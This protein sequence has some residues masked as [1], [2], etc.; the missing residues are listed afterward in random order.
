MVFCVTVLGCVKSTRQPTPWDPPVNRLSQTVNVSIEGCVRR[1]WWRLLTGA[2][3]DAEALFQTCDGDDW[4]RLGLG[5]IARNRLDQTA[6]RRLLTPFIDAPTALGELARKWTSEVGDQ[7]WAKPLPI[8]AR[9][10]SH[11]A[12]LSRLAKAR[13]SGLSVST[14][15][16]INPQFLGDHRFESEPGLLWLQWDLPKTTRC[17]QVPRREHSRVFL[18]S[19]EVFADDGYL[20]VSPTTDALRLTMIIA[21][22]TAAEIR[23]TSSECGKFRYMVPAFIEPGEDEWL[24]RFVQRLFSHRPFVDDALSAKDP[25]GSKFAKSPWYT[26]VLVSLSLKS[27]AWDGFRRALLRHLPA[28]PTP[29]LR[30]AASENYLRINDVAQARALIEPLIARGSNNPEVLSVA[31]RIYSASNLD[32]QGRSL[33]KRYLRLSNRRCQDRAR[34]FGLLGERTQY[35]DAAIQWARDCQQDHHALSLALR[36]YRD[37]QADEIFRSRPEEDWRPRLVYQFYVALGRYAEAQRI[38]E[39]AG[40]SWEARELSDLRSR[41]KLDPEDLEKLRLDAA[42]TPQSLRVAAWFVDQDNPLEEERTTSATVPLNVDRLERSESIGPRSGGHYR[43]LERLD[44][45][46]YRAAQQYSE[47]QLPETAEVPQV[48]VRKK[49]GSLY[50]PLSDA[51]KGSLTLPSLSVSDQIEIRYVEPVS[52]LGG[53]RLVKTQ[54]RPMSLPYGAISDSLYTLNAPANSSWK[55]LTSI[56]VPIE[57]TSHN[58][59]VF[60]RIHQKNVPPVTLHP[61]GP[62]YVFATPVVRAGIGNLEQLYFQREAER[63]QKL[64]RLDAPMVWRECLTLNPAPQDVSLM[65]ALSTLAEESQISHWDPLKFVALLSRCLSV[66]NHQHQVILM[67]P[68]ASAHRR[69]DLRLSAFTYPVLKIDG[70]GLWD[71][72]NS[73]MPM[74]MV[75]FGLFDTDGRVIYPLRKAG[76]VFDGPRS[77]KLP[78]KNLVDIQLQRMG[79]EIIGQLTL[80]F[81][82]QDAW[83]VYGRWRHLNP[84]RRAQLVR[85]LVTEIMPL[86]TVRS[87]EFSRATDGRITFRIETENSGARRLPLRMPLRDQLPTIE[88]SNLPDGPIYVDRPLSFELRVDLSEGLEFVGRPKNTRSRDEWKHNQFGYTLTDEVMN[89]N[90]SVPRQSLDTHELTRWAKFQRTLFD[91]SLPSVGLSDPEP[92]EQERD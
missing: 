37:D 55:V 83:R 75:P 57:K 38:A 89:V 69:A 50:F 87:A 68:R 60:Y 14:V 81:F 85:R 49:N 48:Y 18:A 77:S 10:E 39:D 62:A 70:V 78:R 45:H 43:H 25:D 61:N 53:G 23:V 59:T 41:Q 3:E 16:K 44:I 30:L 56:Q 32:T 17:V 63:F 40:F 36:W 90:V 80:T 20:N 88:S 79:S 74:G 28:E 15:R 52:E 34:V 29:R 4:A 67:A 9:F 71:P 5:Y 12:P 26:E 42:H 72:I 8:A 54:L 86:S 76:N 91:F 21:G 13:I 35:V 24:A 6:T 84:A 82:D 47:L 33:A 2:Y 22:R 31:L 27:E 7:V 46:H 73:G 65:D 92:S 66:G 64:R 51:N 19:E 11:F 1:G 58:G